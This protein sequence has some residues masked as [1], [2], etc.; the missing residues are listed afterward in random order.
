MSNFV[1]KSKFEPK[2]D[3]PEAIERLS[4]NLESGVKDQVLWGVT[5]SGKTFTMANVVQNIQKPTLVIAHNK[6]L[7]AQLADEFRQYFPNNAV[8]YFVS[9]YDYYQPEAYIASTDTY[10]EKDSSINDEIDRLRHAATHALLTRKDVLIVASVS[11]IYGIGSPEFYQSENVILKVGEDI[12]RDQL[13]KSLTNQQYQRNDLELRRGTF[14]LKGDTLEI[15]PAY[16]ENYFRIEFFGDNIEKITEMAW[17]D[18]NV[19]K[20]YQEIEIYPAKHFITPEP[21]L[22]LAISEIRKDL[23]IRLKELKSENKL[24]EY[25]RLEQRTNYD[26]E[27][28]EQT[29]T[30]SGIENYSRYFDQRSPGE[31][32]TTLLDYF[33]HSTSSGQADFLLFI[34]ESHMTVPQIRGMHA[35]DH[36]RKNSLIENG[37]RLPSAFDN[38]PLQ[39]EEFQD[40]IGRTIFV[41]ATPGE[42]ELQ[43][44]SRNPKSEIRNPKEIKNSNFENSKIVSDLDIRDSNFHA[45]VVK[46]FIR[47]TGLIDPEIEVRK[48]AGQIKDLIT[49]IDSRI[50]KKQRV[51]VTTLTKRMA[52]ELTEYLAERKIKVAYIHSDVETLE[53]SEILHSLRLGEYD[54]LVGINLLREGLDLPE[55]SMVAI[56]DADK[57][58]FLRSKTSLVQT[59]GRA[60]RHSEGKVIM[61]ADRITDSMK[62]AISET[63]NR[64][65]LQE[66]YNTEHGIIPTT[67]QKSV[68]PK[69][70]KEEEELKK[71]NKEFKVLPKIEKKRV[72]RDLEQ[73]M[74]EAAKN[75][76]F[77]RAA[78]LRDQII[79]LE[80]LI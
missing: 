59:I 6:T 4:A 42:Y 66:R 61:Y 9:Y 18:N 28:M 23:E 38:R 76:E 49:E 34:D 57:E 20:N 70:I 55:V 52:E 79:K 56:L 67:I 11:C 5:G 16:A 64:R 30:C 68:K 48:T 37:F 13:L 1:L 77:E 43:K 74:E 36:S 41:S 2:G 62:A 58:G 33:P 75:L 46:Q 14:R 45:S 54:V 32:P 72:I 17:P 31:P 12:K 73:L 19:L 44:S 10:I 71:I 78:E 29:G 24:L 40:K 47:P 69:E 80:S 25:Q 50:L 27:I 63:E 51:L 35:G 3:Q 26:L 39:Y 7:A 15:L 53:R 22:K 60:A 8:H 21:I 65:K